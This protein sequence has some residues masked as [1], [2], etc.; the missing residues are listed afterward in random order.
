MNV[1]MKNIGLFLLAAAVCAGAVAAF[2]YSSNMKAAAEAARDKAIAEENAALEKRKS[3]EA[4][5]QQAASEKKAA[6][7]NAEAQAAALENTKL[8]KEDS[9]NRRIEAE[10]KRKA[11][12][13]A[14]AAAE[15][16]LAAAN[17]VR[18]SEKAKE[19]ASL[20]E[21]DRAKALE[22][23]AALK[24]QEAAD[25]LAAEKLRSEKVI[26][27]AKMAELSKID[28]L[29]WERD[30]LELKQDL[31]E[32][33]RAL[34]PE[35]TIADLAWVG[36][37]EDRVFDKNGRVAAKKKEEKPYRAE[38]DPQLPA[39]TRRLAKAE[40]LSTQAEARQAAKIREKIVKS[41]EGLYIE[42]IKAGRVIDAQYY[43]SSLK[44]L[45]PD[46]K[47]EGEKK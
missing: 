5:A 4:L 21:R 23:T 46:W 34:R 29:T 11:Q 32:R 45:Y 6:E 19:A 10:E 15:K 26:A 9:A 12:E 3:D 25:N 40:R 39:E 30:L 14:A 47:F 24:A 17:A 2:R 33:E 28:F 8:A 7:L 41:L 42:A 44:S 27:Q 22:K 18:E 35:K 13:A 43:K 37:G 20:A 31:E 38:D 1:F 36:G 16:S